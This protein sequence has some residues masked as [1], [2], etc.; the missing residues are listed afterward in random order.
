MGRDEI[1]IRA[2]GKHHKSEHRHARK[3]DLWMELTNSKHFQSSRF[4]LWS[5][6]NNP[7][8]ELRKG[9]PCPN[10]RKPLITYSAPFQ[11]SFDQLKLVQSFSPIGH[12]WGTIVAS[13]RDVERPNRLRT[14]AVSSRRSFYPSS[15]SLKSG[16]S[17]RSLAIDHPFRLLLTPQI[18][19]RFRILCFLLSVSMPFCLCRIHMI[20][21]LI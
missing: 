19:I 16:R 7:K 10:T 3:A 8:N 14:T 17:L 18:E 20:T 13:K 1:W 21:V 2:S 9:E 15:L 6:P 5:S 12:L 4:L 11:V